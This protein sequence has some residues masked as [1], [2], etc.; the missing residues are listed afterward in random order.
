M[1]SATALCRHRYRQCT[2]KTTI[3]L[4]EH[5]CKR[6]R[7]HRNNGPVEHDGANPRRRAQDLAAHHQLLARRGEHVPLAVAADELDARLEQRQIVMRWLAVYG[8]S[9]HHR[10]GARARVRRRRVERDAPL[11]VRLAIELQR[12]DER[13][14]VAVRRRRCQHQQISRRRLV[15]LQLDDV[16]DF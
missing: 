16:A 10:A 1:R 4:I 3:G 15:V 5:L 2:R 13:H 6:D 9:H 8:A 14:T 11:Q 7:H 12:L